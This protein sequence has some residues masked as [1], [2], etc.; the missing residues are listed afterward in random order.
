MSR[1]LEGQVQ[2]LEQVFALI[3]ETPRGKNCPAILG[4]IEEGK[5]VMEEYKGSPGVRRGAAVRALS[6]SSIMKFRV[7]ARSSLGP[8]NWA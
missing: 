4:I 6:R 2:R 7:T 1:K 5:E 8:T 3:D